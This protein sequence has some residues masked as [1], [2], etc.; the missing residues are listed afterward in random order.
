MGQSA[1][2]LSHRVY[3]KLPMDFCIVPIVILLVMASLVQSLVFSVPH[4]LAK[5]FKMEEELMLTLK[6]AT[7]FYKSETLDLYLQTCEPRFKQVPLPDFSDLHPLSEPE[8][9]AKVLVDLVGNPIQVYSLMDRLV[10]QL[11][12]LRKELL[13]QHRTATI[14]ERIGGIVNDIEM[15]DK[16]DLE[17]ATQAIARIQ[18]A[19]RLDPVEMAAGKIRG[20]QT[21]GRLSV[22]QMMN[23]AESRISGAQP[24][25][26]AIGKEYALA[27]EWAEG[28]LTITQNKAD[29]EPMEKHIGQ[30]LK[31][32]RI[33]HNSNWR[34]PVGQRGNLPNEEFFVRKIMNNPKLTVG[35]DLRIEETDFLARE[36]AAQRLNQ[37]YNIHDFYALCRGEHVRHSHAPA[38]PM[39]TLTTKNNPYF[40]LAPIKQEVLSLEPLLHLY[41]G[42]LT[43]RE[44][45]FMTTHIM[46]QLT[47]ATVQDI[48]Q[49]DGGGSKV[50]N[51][52]TQ[53]NGWIWDQE[54]ELLYKLS[55]KTGKL[56]HLETTRPV[57]EMAPG[58][59]W[60]FVES[61]AWQMGLYGPGGHYLPHFDA[62]DSNLMPPDVW[63]TD[64]LWVGNRIATVMFYLSDLVGGS[65][66]FPNMGVA[67][68]PRKG[69]AVFWYNMDRFGNRDDLALHGACPTALGIKWVSNK[70]IRDGA[71][72]WK[73]PCPSDTF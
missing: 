51:E 32:A 63:G 3:I 53:S 50:S 70:W 27:I 44:I 8:Y 45:Q 49:S 42:I 30:F 38:K 20:V 6:M 25:R 26:P 23:I 17:G 10:V 46:S 16:N 52:R 58:V 65:T 15:P 41:H 22:R 12:V 40:Y 18:F 47:A 19:Y 21:E 56:V 68:T 11:P 43:D 66:A 72:I 60:R 14:E 54:S 13:E 64:R 34:S 48:A 31:N 4:Q 73:N 1:N 36:P 37:G 5:L 2:L 59:Q 71:Q 7:G 9:L 28:A 55:K 69:S 24:M 39:C 35:M 62:F 61:E 29:D 57:E 67:A 33:E